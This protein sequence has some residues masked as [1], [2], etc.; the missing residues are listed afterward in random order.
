MPQQLV[1]NNPWY[2]YKPPVTKLIRRPSIRDEGYMTYRAERVP[3]GTDVDMSSNLLK[4]RKK[5]PMKQRYNALQ[6]DVKKLPGQYKSIA[7]KDFSN[8]STRRDMRRQPSLP[9]PVE[10]INPQTKQHI[11][12]DKF[13]LTTGVVIL[14]EAQDNFKLSTSILGA[15]EQ[16]EVNYDLQQEYSKRLSSP[17][18]ENKSIENVSYRDGSTAKDRTTKPA[19]PKFSRPGV[20]VG[21]SCSGKLIPPSA[22]S[23]K[24][25]DAAILKIQ[26]DRENAKMTRAERV[27]EYDD[28]RR[29]QRQQERMLKQQQA[30][31]GKAERGMLQSQSVPRLPLPDRST[32]QQPSPQNRL[33][34][35]SRSTRVLTQRLDVI[36]E[37]LSS[38][39]NGLGPEKNFEKNSD[40]FKAWQAKKAGHKNTS[41]VG[42]VVAMST[43]RPLD[44]RNSSNVY[45]KMQRTRPF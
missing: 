15:K 8:P 4:R 5:S 20:K 26:A 24:R 16:K 32:T 29:E 30:T 34:S 36:N 18:R 41:A 38:T 14:S 27:K 33:M 25:L 40:S 6:P 37:Q 2:D 3:W 31:Q 7:R 21:T 42:S 13:P 9:K 44:S 28:K 10:Q 43:C 17:S 12:V 11:I 1:F 45:V 23:K 39:R 35:S 19:V 22:K